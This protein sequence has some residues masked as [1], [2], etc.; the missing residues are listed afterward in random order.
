[1]KYWS[2]NYFNLV[3]AI[4]SAV[5]PQIDKGLDNHKEMLML[6]IPNMHIH[7]CTTVTKC[8]NMTFAF[9]REGWANKLKCIR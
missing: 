8:A 1:M 5:I 7:A 6:C 4:R 3:G 9:G 2:G